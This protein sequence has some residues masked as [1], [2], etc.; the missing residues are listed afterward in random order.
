MVDNY[1]SVLK[2]SE[3]VAVTGRQANP[4]NANREGALTCVS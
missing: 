1:E 4:L 3:F 2:R